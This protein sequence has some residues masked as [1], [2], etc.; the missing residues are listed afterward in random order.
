MASGTVVGRLAADEA[1][2][3]RAGVHGMW[4]AV[5]PGWAEQAEYIDARGEALT[6]RMLDAAALRP[7][8][9][10]LE[11]ACGPGGTGLAAARRVL[12]GGEVVLSDVAPPMT[13]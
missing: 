11:L 3:I 7:G 9:R 2:G 4:A 6:E 8:D 13:A 10:A 1:E 5:A 12:P